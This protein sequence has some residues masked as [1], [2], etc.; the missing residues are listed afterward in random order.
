MKIC[1]SMK[2]IFRSL[3]SRG[4][5]KKMFLWKGNVLVTVQN[6][7]NYIIKTILNAYLKIMAGFTFSYV[8]KFYYGSPKILSNTVVSS[9]DYPQW[10]ETKMAVTNPKSENN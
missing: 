3:K 6:F 9:I 8:D 1:L 2:I 5:K 7:I 4:T 10:F